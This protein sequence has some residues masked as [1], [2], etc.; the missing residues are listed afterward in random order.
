MFV[1]YYGG[2]KI[3]RKV[4]LRLLTDLHKWITE[5]RDYTQANLKYLFNLLMQKRQ[6]YY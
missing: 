5:Q 3:G 4:C 1:T 6:W 2:N